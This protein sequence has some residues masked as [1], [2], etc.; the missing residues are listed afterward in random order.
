M[1][2]ISAYI[3]MGVLVLLYI[4]F[5]NTC[6]AQPG[7]G[8]SNE[9]K[10]SIRYYESKGDLP[11]KLSFLRRQEIYFMESGQTEQIY[12][13]DKYFYDIEDPEK[14]D[15]FELRKGLIRHA[16]TYFKRI[17]DYSKAKEFYL[18]AYKLL[19]DKINGDSWSWY[20]ENEL[21]NIFSRFGDFEQAFRYLK[22]AERQLLSMDKIDNRLSRLYT[23]LGRLH[24]IKGDRD[25]ARGF[26][27]KGIKYG[28]GF[29]K[30]LAANY[31]NLAEFY[32]EDENHQKAQ[33]LLRYLDKL[34][35]KEVDERKEFILELEAMILQQQGRLEEADLKF[36]ESLKILIDKLETPY[37]RETS[38]RLI[39]KAK[40]LIEANRLIDAEKNLDLALHYLIPSFD[41]IKGGIPDR[42]FVY[43]ENTFINILSTKADIYVQRYVSGIEDEDN[44]YLA[45]LSL[46]L[47]RD[48]NDKL[49]LLQI[50]DA[51]KLVN[52]RANK[53]LINKA[54]E[55]EYL[56]YQDKPEQ[57]ILDR[58]R[59][60]MNH[61]KALLLKDK[62]GLTASL[63]KLQKNERD[64][65]LSNRDFLS[66]LYD[67]KR[68]EQDLDSIEQIYNRILDLE[69]EIQ[70]ILRNINDDPVVL[71]DFRKS[72]VEYI[73]TDKD[74]YS[75]NN[76]LGDVAFINHGSSEELLELIEKQRDGVL[77]KI[78][79]DSLKAL[80]YKLYNFLFKQLSPTEKYI[81]IIPDD[82]ISLVNFE[83]LV[84]DI[85]TGKYLVESNVISYAY[86]FDQLYDEHQLREDMVIFCL[87]P[88]YSKELPSEIEKQDRSALYNL[89]YAEQEINEL[90]AIWSQTGNR[91]PGVSKRSLNKLLRDKS[92]FH[93]AGHAKAGE[94]EAYLA[95][96]DERANVRLNYEEI[97]L[98]NLDLDM[99]TLSA[100]ET[101][102]GELAY[103]EGVLSLARSFI[104][105]GA[106]SV[107]TS[108][109]AVNDQST[110]KLMTD[111]Y[112]H[113]KKGKTK[114]QAL[115]QAKLNFIESSPPEM[116][117]PYY[118]AGF[119]VV[120]DMQ[121]LAPNW[122]QNLFLVGV[123]LGIVVVMSVMVLGKKTN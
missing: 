50:N 118:W 112:Y 97:E 12:A 1:P 61:S 108:L 95:L 86:H 83:S 23:N 6:A 98:M 80:S 102:L 91:R 105:A 42:D 30:S 25:K 33:N 69:K 93:Y 120:G 79:Q 8:V 43:P 2:S 18:R 39:L 106:A 57:I 68:N 34:D 113:L 100:C 31:I 28:E 10:D 71:P 26:F 27:E 4:C 99:V 101:G 21:G 104:S 92:I 52:I 24:K 56:K 49:R 88:R 13:L 78:R 77:G 47:A 70:D 72:F 35:Q 109:W 111:Y 32:L 67:R 59:D 16:H 121:A 110:S 94:N 38:K 123:F 82:I 14:E 20:A 53:R 75:L 119:V 85:S 73:V 60:L 90:L 5:G 54:V 76:R 40:N 45:T 116:R 74:V 9:I 81:T 115:Q 122:T 96:S 46:D 63:D 7:P 36:A 107:V 41:T 19:D 89:K 55:L 62:S 103:G 84:P 3:R 22:I 48:A 44:L 15:R 114:D 29:D 51:S 58:V 65:I 17:G 66:Q 87:S 117:H 64:R 37:R 11:G